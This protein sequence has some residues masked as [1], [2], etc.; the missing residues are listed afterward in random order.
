[1]SLKRNPSRNVINFAAGPSAMPYDV[2]THEQR[3][4]SFLF[5]SCLTSHHITHSLLLT[6]F[7]VLE[8]AQRELVD[9]Q[10][11]GSSVMGKFISITMLVC[12]VLVLGITNERTFCRDKSPISDIR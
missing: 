8:T 2:C 4:F 12:L 9:F 3:L 1:M 6:T 5:C 11:L 10:N 7:K